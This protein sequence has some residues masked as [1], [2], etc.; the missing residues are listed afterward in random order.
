MT[1]FQ[2]SDCFLFFTQL[3]LPKINIG[4]GRVIY[5]IKATSVVSVE[6]NRFE[7]FKL[8]SEFKRD[9][10]SSNIFLYFTLISLVFLAIKVFLI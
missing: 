2:L 7:I 10:W 3:Q 8:K 5:H 1:L 4:V 6:K 9:E